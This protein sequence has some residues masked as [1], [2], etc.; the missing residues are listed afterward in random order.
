MQLHML[1]LYGLL[2]EAGY[3]TYLGS[4]LRNSE[5]GLLCT[6]GVELPVCCVDLWHLAAVEEECCGTVLCVLGVD[7]M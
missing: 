4:C 2:S 6:C 1:G 7:G 3:L 5:F